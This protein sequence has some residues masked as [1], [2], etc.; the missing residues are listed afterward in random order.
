MNRAPTQAIASPNARRGDLEELV[1]PTAAN[2]DIE[3]SRDTAIASAIPTSPE[4]SWRMSQ[5]RTRGTE[6]ELRLRSIL[7][8]RALRYRVDRQPCTAVRRRADLVFGSARVAVFVDGCFWHGCPEHA[9]WPKSNAE[10][11]RAKIEKSRRRD[12]RTTRSLTDASWMVIRIW[13]HEPPEDAADR[14]EV[15]V[16]DRRHRPLKGTASPVILR[17]QPSATVI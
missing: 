3:V 9:S 5:V 10:W 8:R 14:V 11:W 4:V 6:P 1:M 7:H 12:E 13:A 2:T 15:A 16:L 17:S